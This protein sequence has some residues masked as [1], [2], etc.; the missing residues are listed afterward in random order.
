MR[1]M[2]MLSPRNLISAAFGLLLIVAGVVLNQR[3]ASLRRP[4][5]QSPE[6]VVTP[7]VETIPLQATTE[8]LIIHGFGTIRAR[9]AAAL[10]AE[11]AG[12]VVF[13]HPGFEA[14][15]EVEAGQVLLR[16]DPEPY[17]LQVER[18]EAQLAQNLAQQASLED[19][20]AGYRA[21]L[22]VA[23]AAVQLARREAARF[24]RLAQESAT[25]RSQADKTEA[26]LQAALAAEVR[27]QNNLRLALGRRPALK[28]AEQQARAALAEARLALQRT[29][30]VAPFAGRIDRRDIEAGEY[31]TPGKVV[32]ALH[33]PSTFEVR[34]PVALSD[35]PW[36]YSQAAMGGVAS[37]AAPAGPTLERREAEVLLCLPT[38]GV[39]A[40]CW[41][42][43]VERI[44]QTV[45][46]RTRTVEVVV[47]IPLRPP[48]TGEAP[49]PLMQ[50]MFVEVALQGRPV[51]GVFRIPRGAVSNRDTVN[52]WREGR[53]RVTPCEILRYD[54]DDAF[55]RFPTQAGDRLIVS[56]VPT[57]VD[58]MPLQAA[59]AAASL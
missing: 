35:L 59:T 13:R 45:A 43:R 37:A 15:G 1:A 41:R 16:I 51:E 4:P 19:E 8:P 27:D 38:R 33:D 26:A 23:S 30:I 49:V 32:G 46:E 7:L 42:G 31:V 12:R 55:V 14:G 22:A 56:P 53:L 29:E 47:A 10:A 25:S 20:I 2:N 5:V 18:A 17:R 57:P 58:G 9:V 21:S 52:L 39:A 40:A 24:E 34:I 3:L 54:R 36:L 28:A 6:T 50:G 44:G 11:V 48:V